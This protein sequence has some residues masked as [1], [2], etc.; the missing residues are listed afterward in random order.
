MSGHNAGDSGV[1]SCIAENHKNFDIPARTLDGGLYPAEFL[2]S[3][4]DRAAND[5]VNRSFPNCRI[6]HDTSRDVPTFALELRL[7]QRGDASSR[8]NERCDHRKNFPQRYERHIHDEHL[9]RIR[10]AIGVSELAEKTEIDPFEQDDP[11]VGPEA[12]MEQS[13]P[14]I[15]AVH[16]PG[17]PPQ[18]QVGE[19][20]G[21]TP[22]VET[23]PIS[24]V[25]KTRL[26][27]CPQ[28]L[29]SP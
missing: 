11:W 17:A 14:D 3:E 5:A 8:C 16:P 7:Y 13:A 2:K 9:G 12:L 4:S 21:R 29:G 15:A 26:E 6:P 20:A 23:D 24:Y 22:H 28:L 10:H 19:P 1:V 27:H 25:Q 18:E